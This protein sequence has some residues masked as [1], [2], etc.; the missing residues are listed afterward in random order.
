M[1]EKEQQCLLCGN[2]TKLMTTNQPGYKEPDQFEIHYCSLCNTS[3]SIP[4]E[5]NIDEIYELIYRNAHRLPG[6]DRYHRYADEVLKH[7]NPI[8]WLINQEPNYWSVY[9][10][11][12]GNAEKNKDLK[13]LEVGSGLGYFTYAMCK[14]GYNVTGV[15]IS[16]EAVNKANE[17]YGDNYICFDI[18]KA[19]DASAKYD[20]IVLTEVIEHI[21]DPIPFFQKLLFLLKKNGQII[22]TTPNKSF[23]PRNSVWITDL[24]PV[25]CWW[26]SEESFL[27]IANQLN[28]S[29]SFVDFTPYYKKHL[30]MM[31]DIKN[32]NRMK[33]NYIFNEDGEL[34]I[35]YPR[36]NK[37][38]ILPY[39]AKDNML[40]KY[41]S[42]KLYPFFFRK[43]FIISNHGQTNCLCAIIKLIN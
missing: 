33:I 18:M 9:K 36:K 10:V 11:I 40:Y 15:D 38:G 30:K 20:I 1:K 41:L 26:F 34:S 43:R 6:Y 39:W 24:P 16:Q 5:N 32:C 23:F 29:V 37:S 7:N 4:R 17:K 3:F 27:Q 31:Y 21:N 35:R 12:M 13:I 2:T 42:R 22:L 8:E 25:H 14:A 28:C 19:N